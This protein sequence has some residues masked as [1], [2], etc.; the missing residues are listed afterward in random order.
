MKIVIK[1]NSLIIVNN[2]IKKKPQKTTTKFVYSMS[3]CN[4][5]NGVISDLILD[6]NLTQIFWDELVR[7]RTMKNSLKLVLNRFL[8]TF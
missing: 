6:K 2:I 8:K 3:Q 4:T 7:E 1:T 5:V